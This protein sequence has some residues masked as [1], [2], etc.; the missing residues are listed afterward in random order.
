MRA[1]LAINQEAEAW[2]RAGEWNEQSGTGSAGKR[3][4]KDNDFKIKR[5][6]SH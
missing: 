5:E 1:G 3:T 6:T 4:T 2:W